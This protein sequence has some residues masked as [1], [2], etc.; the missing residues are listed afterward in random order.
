MPSHCPKC[1]RERRPGEDAC[2]RCGLLVTRW[3]GFE[4]EVP[5][6]PPGDPV[7]RA[8]AAL[9]GS[10]QDDA[11][12]KRFLEQA[13]TFD[14]LDVAAAFYRKRSNADPTDG[15]AR[16]GLERTAL[17]AQEV[18][19]AKARHAIEVARGPRWAGRAVLASLALVAVVAGML[20]MRLFARR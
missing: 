8:W 14:E 18:Y 5:N 2:A 12:H 15:K 1:Q 3:E 17:L 7:G 4:V 16:A 9:E 10:W 6:L 13:A 19:V 20:L 11:A